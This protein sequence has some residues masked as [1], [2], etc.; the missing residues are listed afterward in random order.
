MSYL[1]I[2]KGYEITEIPSVTDMANV[3]HIIFFRRSSKHFAT[4]FHLSKN[5][6]QILLNN[7]D[8]FITLCYCIDIQ[9]ISN[10]LNLS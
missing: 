5:N 2:C 1:G 3:I 4:D 8:Y 10:P 7:I 6:K 9:K